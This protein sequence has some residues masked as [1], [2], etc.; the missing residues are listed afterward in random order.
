[1]LFA[2]LTPRELRIGCGIFV[3]VIAL[4]MVPVTARGQADDSNPA[5]EKITALN[6][7]ALDAYNDLEFEESRKLLKQALDLCTSAGLDKHPVAARTHIHMGVVLI[8]AKQQ[9][10][11][12]KQFKTA[13]EIE[14]EIQVTKALAN[15]EIL[16]AFKAAGADV[17]PAAGGDAGGQPAASDAAK[18]AATPEEVKGIQLNPP[19]RGKRG[20]AIP[21]VVT[22][23]ADVT[24]YTKVMLEYRPEGASEYLEREMKK[25]GNK[26]AGEIPADATEGN[27]VSY[28]V[29]ADSDDED[30]DSIATS[31]SEDRPYNVSLSGGASGG[32]ASGGECQGD[33]CDED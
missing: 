31:G 33:D 4:A 1:M 20:K 3:T 30:A 17:T 21:I 15:P 14:P 24:G 25:S 29:E 8:A 13:I 19:A 27:L 23:G 12:I 16:E 9:D 22:I 6:K 18:P 2:P 7:K 10:L 5:I 26:Y 28:Y 32:E 11:G